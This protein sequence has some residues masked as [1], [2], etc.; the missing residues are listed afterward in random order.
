[1]AQFVNLPNEQ[2][3]MHYDFQAFPHSLKEETILW[4]K[5]QNQLDSVA[6]IVYAGWHAMPAKMDAFM[7]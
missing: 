4:H 6:G 1:M 5:M 3:W 2:I 7:A